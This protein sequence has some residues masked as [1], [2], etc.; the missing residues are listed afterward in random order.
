MTG[1]GLHA[2]VY[3][4]EDGD[5]SM[6]LIPERLGVLSARELE[7][8]DVFLE[9]AETGTPLMLATMIERLSEL[10]PVDC[11]DCGFATDVPELVAELRKGAVVS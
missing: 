1:V 9:D 11:K 10:V 5:L 6:T 4:D 7:A 2:V 3:L 8:R